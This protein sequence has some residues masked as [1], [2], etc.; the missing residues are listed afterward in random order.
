MGR[1]AGRGMRARGYGN[2]VGGY[3]RRQRGGFRRNQNQQQPL[4]PV[5]SAADPVEGDETLPAGLID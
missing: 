5:D 4:V 1:I 2:Q 3:G